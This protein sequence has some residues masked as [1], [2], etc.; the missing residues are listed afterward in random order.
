MSHLITFENF[1]KVFKNN[2]IGPINFKVRKGKVLG[3]LG[4]SGSGK[5]VLINSLIGTIKKFKGNINVDNVSR[6]SR[7]YYKIN[8]KIGFYVQMD[9]SLYE[10]SAYKYLLNMCIIFG[11]NS[12]EAKRR[13]EHWLTFFDLWESKNKKLK[14]FSWGMK[15]R[16]NLI[17]CFIKEPEIL[18]LDEPGANLDSVWR[19]RVKNLL[20]KYTNEGKTIIITAHNIDEIADII[21]DYVVLESG[22]KIFEGSKEELDIY[23]KFKIFIKDSFDIVSFRK[24]LSEKNIKSFKYDENENSLVVS[25]KDYKQL[26]YLIVYLIKNLLLLENL[27]KLPVNI[28]AINKAIESKK[29]TE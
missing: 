22:N 2:K 16:I 7:H 17:M 29:N 25:I 6:K 28:E 10:I 9:F 23:S 20:I 4:D 26:N 24:F 5:S 27:V 21:D 8:S 15:N 18:I 19:N 3:L 13:V 11:I 14:D 12:N 1:E